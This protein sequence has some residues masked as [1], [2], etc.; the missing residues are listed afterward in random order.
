M[1][2]TSIAFPW[3]ENALALALGLA[4]IGLGAG[5]AHSQ[6]RATPAQQATAPAFS[7]QAQPGNWCDLRDWRGFAQAFPQPESLQPESK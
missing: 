6:T 7:C 5:F 4:I 2:A 1:K 3:R